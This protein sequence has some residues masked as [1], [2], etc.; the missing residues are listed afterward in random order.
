MADH[1]FEGSLAVT[2]SVG[3]GT[4]PL[5]NAQ[6]YIRSSSDRAQTLVENSDGGLLKLAIDNNEIT[7]GSDTGTN[8]PLNLQTNGRSRLSI[9]ASG[10]V[11]IG[12]S[13]PSERLEVDGIVK[14]AAFRGD[15]SALTNIKNVGNGVI[16][17]SQI[18]DKAVKTIK[19]DND[20]VDTS[21]L[22]NGAVTTLKITDSAVNTAK[23]ADN[24][25]STGKLANGAV[26]AQK[27]ANS[28]VNTA[29]LVDNS[30]STGKLA[31]GAVTTL[32]ITDSAV[33]ASKLADN[34]VSTG[35]LANG[36][37]TAQKIA[38]SAVN[39]ANLVDNS[40]STGKLAN[41]AVT[42]SKI[43]EI[44]V[45]KKHI[46]NNSI[47]IAQ[48]NCDVIFDGEIGFQ[49]DEKRKTISIEGVLQGRHNF[50]IISL[51]CT[52]QT[53][54]NEHLSWHQRIVS[55]VSSFS[56]SSLSSR[57]F[58]PQIGNDLRSPII[59]PLSFRVRQLV[60]ERNNSSSPI[61]VH[62]KIYRLNET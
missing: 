39:T 28:A 8:L 62:C 18:A 43:A 49:K 47:A 6:L 50:Y 2:G 29:N 27:I 1:N 48:L 7:V 15:G 31:N 44:S 9:S 3:I 12:S 33:N 24:S 32:K 19:L 37:V 22:A 21:K 30:V 51:F 13:N 38:N 35:K 17:T 58:P 25:V 5:S 41:G 42:S 23:L 34:S 59:R 56:R 46:K 11:G 57:S 61:S 4:E 20:S 60:I 40:V 54:L 36:A 45:E 10:N 53:I 16:D 52:G 26:T 14:A 55:T